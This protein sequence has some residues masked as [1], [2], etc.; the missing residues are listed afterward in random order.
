MVNLLVQIVLLF[1]VVF[2]NYFSIVSVQTL[3]ALIAQQ[4]IRLGC[5]FFERRDDD[6]F[7]KW[8]SFFHLLYVSR[9]SV[10]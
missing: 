9:K 1:R 2:H 4:L 3:V 10:C 6:F 7:T 8:A 5:F